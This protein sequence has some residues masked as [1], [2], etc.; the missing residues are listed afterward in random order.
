MGKMLKISAFKAIRNILREFE[1]YKIENPLEQ[2]SCLSF[3]V[4]FKFKTSFH[5]FVIK[6]RN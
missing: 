1:L 6:F 3:S 2:F 4:I 5:T